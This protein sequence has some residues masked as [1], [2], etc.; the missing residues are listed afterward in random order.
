MDGYPYQTSVESWDE[1]VLTSVTNLYNNIAAII[2][3][4]IG[5][6][7]VLI[8][9]WI[10]ALLVK[11]I[12][13]VILNLVHFDE[14]AKRVGLNTFLDRASFRISPKEAVGEV[15]KWFIV[16]AFVLAA[17]SILGL[18]AVTEMLNSIVGYI[19]KVIAAVLILTGGL[20]IANIVQDLLRGAL[21]SFGVDVSDLMASVA[22]WILV[23]LTILAVIRQLEIV[24]DL[25][26]VVFIGLIGAVALAFGLAFGL[27][28]KDVASKML[29][30]WYE[31]MRRMNR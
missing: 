25:I 24:P 19:P 30:E 15:V 1:A 3:N 28:G 27:G 13:I 16:V 23:V 11:R 21:K 22:R 17:L 31:S 29:S 20:L 5:A 9:G 4:I 18:P 26:N 2:P 14:I 6:V 10:I 7:V 12:V 8:L